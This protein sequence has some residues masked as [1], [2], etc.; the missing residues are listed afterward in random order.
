M[1]IS[2]L[3]VLIAV[4]SLVL[5]AVPGF[6]L[7][8]FKML[9]EKTGE[10]LSA[11]VLYGAQPAMIFMSFQEY[12]NATIAR[13]LIWVL[14]L[15]AAVHLLMIGIIYLCIRNKDKS[16][17]KY[18]ARYGCLFG[19]CGFMGLPFLEIVFGGTG[20]GGEIIIY[21]AII[22]AVFNIL[23]WTLGVYMITGDKKDISAKKIFLNPTIISIFIG[24]IIF[25]TVQTPFVDLTV[26]GSDARFIVEKLMNSVNTIGQ[27]VTPLSLTVIGL[28]LARVNLRSLFLDKWSYVVCALKLIV[29]S[30]LTILCVSFLP[31]DIT[32]KYVLFFLLS[33]P[34]ATSTAL[35]AV[36]FGSDGDFGS[37]C[38]LLSTIISIVTI[39]L[40][41]LLMSG[42]FVPI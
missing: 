41:Y 40:M 1:D 19:N 26:E 42:V 2:F 12:Y 15:A 27:M 22:I 3:T 32:V 38:V 35:F 29:M 18:V 34:S 11:I 30:L 10:A 28:R 24:A 13:N 7:E 9:P 31:V 4:L 20:Y 37:I 33:M 39:P 23:N 6:L 5:L 17:K 36:R 14:L 21:A 25:F 8:K 16:A